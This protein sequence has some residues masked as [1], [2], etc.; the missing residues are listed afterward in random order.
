VTGERTTPEEVELRVST[1]G[2]MIAPLV[3]LWPQDAD[4]SCDCPSRE[5]ACVHVAAAVIALNQARLQ[6]KAL[7]QPAAPV[8]RL[9][10]RF[11]R[12]PGGLALE[13][14]LVHGDGEQRLELTL[15]AVAQ[16]RGPTFVATQTDLAV[17]V[18]LGTRTRG[19]MACQLMRKLLALLVD[20]PDVQVEGKTVRVAE[21]RP[22]MRARLG[23]RPD[24]SL[25]LQLIQD[26]AITEVFANGAVLCGDV[27]RAVEDP[28]LGDREMEELRRGQ[29]FRAD[30]LARLVTVVLP[31]LRHRV[32]VDTAGVTLPETSRTP[33]RIVCE[34][35]RDGDALTVLPTLVYGD[36][37]QAR[38]DAGELRHLRGAVPIRDLDA[39]TRQLQHLQ[40][41]TGLEVGRRVTVS[42]EAAVKLAQRLHTWA[43]A[44]TGEAHRAYFVAPALAPRLHIDGD[45]FDVSFESADGRQTHGRA[46]PKAV[47][48]AWQLGQGMVQLMEGGW[49][50]LP[51][52]WLAKHGQRVLDLLL[53]KEDADTLPPHALPDLARLCDDL[54]H[55]KPPSL[56]RLQA[57]LRDFDGIPEAALPADLTAHLRDYQRRGVNWLAFLRKTGMGAM[58]ADDMGLGKT[59]QAL[60]AVRG[61]TLVVAPA[62]VLFNWAD[63]AKRFRPHLRVVV[64]HGAG[65]RLEPDADI[66]L[67]TYAILRLDADALSAQ[68]WDTAVL[69][70]AQTIKNPDSQVA[71]AAFRLRAAFRITLTGTPVEN[72]LD[73]L[74]SQFHFLN[75]GLLGGR[76]DFQDRYARPIAAAEPGVAARLRERIRPFML[77]RLKREVAPE[78][79]PRTD[80]V[81]RC[82]LGAAERSVYDAVRAA[83]MQEVVSKLREGGSVIAALEA[84]LRLRQACCHSALIP[85]QQATSSAK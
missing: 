80:L 71:Q 28:K 52:S 44:V 81:L 41:A 27:L 45:R 10:Y 40:Q 73:E 22:V 32:P 21:A 55:P 57:Q 79:P 72:R 13:R 75:R 56:T 20:C 16:G 36:P 12:A 50:P 69:D 1:Q 46:D 8:A 15:A 39:E 82:A 84:L 11:T 85:G 25:L 60:C 47:L 48:R 4:W 78:L 9:S 43:G 38:I 65:R 54:D 37:P 7:P 74:W 66:T 14:Y 6:G 30:E 67:T 18:M 34:T 63:E 59:L 49:A 68:R 17:E 83:T 29:V 64:Y 19:V 5:E 51:A 42:G 53:A 76:Q 24:G 31:P 77:R 58:L 23:K 2:G 33:P 35:G 62:S 3:T 70:E 26:P 61:R